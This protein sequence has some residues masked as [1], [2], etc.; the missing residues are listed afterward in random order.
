M[1]AKVIF[2]LKIIT[3]HMSIVSETMRFGSLSLSCNNSTAEE[4]TIP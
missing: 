1:A 3:K 2:K 4:K